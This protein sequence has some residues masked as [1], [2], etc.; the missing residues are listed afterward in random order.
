MIKVEVDSNVFLEIT[1]PSNVTACEEEVLAYRFTGKSKEAISQ[2]LGKS[3]STVSAQTKKGFQKLGVSGSDNPLAI[4]QTIS[5]LNG[6]ARF[7]SICLIIISLLPTP[8]LKTQARTK[9]GSQMAGGRKTDFLPV[10]AII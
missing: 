4:L 7:A 2:I 1:F 6:W 9:Q 3:I 10:T 8:R 5:F